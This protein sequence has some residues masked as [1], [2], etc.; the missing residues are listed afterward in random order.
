MNYGVTINKNALKKNSMQGTKVRYMF[1]LTHNEGGHG[2]KGHLEMKTPN[3][4]FYYKAEQSHAKKST[5]KSL[6]LK[7]HHELFV[8][9]E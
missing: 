4:A 5:K 8:Q 1:I 3:S 7:V 9:N 2:E 6:H